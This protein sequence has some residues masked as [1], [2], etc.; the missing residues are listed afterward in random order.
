VWAK[1][2][3]G[4]ALNSFNKLRGFS[5]VESLRGHSLAC[6]LVLA[7]FIAFSTPARLPGQTTE[8]ATIS[9][10]IQRGKLAEAEQ[11]LQ[12]YLRAHPHSAKANALLAEIYLANG[13]F[14]KSLE[15]AENIPPGKRS[16]ELLPTLAAD[17]FGLQQPEKASLEI[18]SMLQ[19][20]DKQPDLIP[21]LAE[22]FLAH[23]DFKSS[24]QLLTL[25]KTKQPTTA[26]FL[27]ALARTQAGLG[28][29]DEAQTILEDVLARRPD[30]VDALIAAGNVAAQQLN[31]QASGEAFARA[32]LLAPNRPDILYGLAHAQL[33]TYKQEAALATVRSLQ[34]LL[35]GDLRVTYL[36]S[37]ASFGVK[38]WANSRKYA[39]QVLAVH[40]EDREMHL[41]LTDIFVN[42]EQ[43]LAIA[44]SHAN[45][46]LK[47]N[48]EDAAAL[49]YMGMI[50]RLEGDV[51]GAI[52][53]L[54]K[55]VKINPRSADAQAALG[56][57][58]LQAGDFL[59]AVPALEQAMQLA[60]DDPSNHYQ[61]ALAYTRAGNLDKA[62]EQLTMYQQM[63]V[64]ADADAKNSKGPT[65]SAVP[66][67]GVGSRP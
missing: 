63:K 19:V 53:Q 28:Q 17:Y 50:Q 37:L 62:R 6:T 10:L 32:N 42:Y 57:V 18:Q 40:P 22:F 20:A 51:P 61:L 29:L 48:S 13:E 1:I 60:P 15:A 39:E 23:R 47:Q 25:A 2:S 3:L 16:T 9:S 36:S 7:G 56:A 66:L 34:Q 67:M 43:N 49:Y 5:L 27:I 24:E 21:E 14:A 11:K 54:T 35:P 31:W 46:V 55:S 33:L 64:K 4:V 52:Q 58:C 38:D 44:K 8:L 59:H 41:I 65:T 45:A 12:S 30:S 26:R